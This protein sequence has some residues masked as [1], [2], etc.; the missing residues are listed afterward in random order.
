MPRLPILALACLSAL[1]AA[2][3][4]TGQVGAAQNRFW[5]VN[6]GTR[7]VETVFV[8]AAR[9]SDWGPDILGAAVL[10]PGRRAWVVPNFAD[11][12][13]DLRVTFEGGGEERRMGVDACRLSQ[14]VVG[15]EAPAGGAR[16]PAGR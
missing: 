2:A 13:L 5:L 11:C 14:I 15:R 3:Q 16:P 6:E 4:G 12:M 10:P 8:S 9:E 1:P 7:V